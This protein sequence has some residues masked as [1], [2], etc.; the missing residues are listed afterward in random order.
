LKEGSNKVEKEF[1]SQVGTWWGYMGEKL[2]RAPEHM[3]DKGAGV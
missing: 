1:L 2:P 3:P